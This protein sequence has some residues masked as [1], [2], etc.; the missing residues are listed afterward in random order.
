[1]DT[2]LADRIS[3]TLK[4]KGC[5]ITNQ[6]RAIIEAAFGTSEHFTAERLI[7][8][9][10]RIDPA[11]SRATVYRTLPL[12]VETGFLKEVDLGREQKHYDPNFIEHPH[13]NHLI[14]IDCGKVHEFEDPHMELL[15]DC[16]ARRLGFSASN[17]V[18]RIEATCDRL[19]LNGRC[20]IKEQRETASF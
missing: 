17:K 20:E 8:M 12:L 13:H 6:R 14:C 2:D 15:E 7:E 9:A 3:E 5:R 18:L 16:I 4:Q 11:T 19:R 1:M 10:R